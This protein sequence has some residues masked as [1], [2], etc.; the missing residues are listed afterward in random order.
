MIKICPSCKGEFRTHR[1]VRKFCSCRC[2]GVASR[3]R[4]VLSDRS[5][6][7]NPNWK[8]GRRIDKGGYIMVYRPTHPFCTSDGYVREHRLVMEK[9]LRR[10]LNTEEVVHHLNKNPSD[11][12]LKNLRLLSRIEHNFHH[13]KDAHIARKSASLLRK[14]SSKIMLKNKKE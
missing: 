5:G 7:H 2:Y 3:G 14:L 13:L 1:S 10:Y 11:N 9:K 6:R 12:R 8:G 4:K